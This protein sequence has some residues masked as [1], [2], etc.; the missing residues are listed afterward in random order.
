VSRAA[1]TCLVLFVGADPFHAQAQA[2]RLEGYPAVGAPPT[3]TLL[4]AGAAPRTA[5]RYAVPASYTERLNMKMVMGMAMDMA[6][7][8]MPEMSI[9]A[10]NMTADLAVT[11]VS[12]TG[13]VTYGVR[14]SGATVETALGVNPA[15][16]AALQGLDA[17]VKAIKGTC[18]ISNRGLIRSATFDLG[19][20]G[21]PQLSQMI[22][23]A[24]STLQSM[25]MPLPEEDVGVGARWEVRQG[26]A[27]N[28]VQMFQKTTMELVTFDGKTA[29]LTATIEQTAPPQA[30]S[31][32]AMPPG[33]DVQLDHFSGTGTAAISLPL[34]GLVPTSEAT[35]NS[36]MAM[37]L[38]MGGNEQ[39][40]T[41]KISMKIGIAPV[42]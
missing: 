38:A 2:P 16:A 29:T 4:A 31:S 6:G 35:M 23:S 37:R 13:D 10:I 25:S 3:V 9:P 11:A 17:T 42:K 12:A 40:M 7:M 19:N 1:I 24:S 32:P 34:V 26:L 27:S 36:D 39:A 41:I 30:V 33:T 8:S 21:D 5:L 15:L 22:N 18:T 20:G 28:G 14:F